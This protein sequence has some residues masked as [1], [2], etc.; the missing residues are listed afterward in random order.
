MPYIL[1]NYVYGQCYLKGFFNA[2]E[3]WR[4]ARDLNGWC[5]SDAV[6]AVTNLEHEGAPKDDYA[7]GYP[8]STHI[9][10]ELVNHATAL[11]KIFASDVPLMIPLRPTDSHKIR[12]TVGDASAEG[13]SIATQYPD[14]TIS[15]RDGLWSEAFAEGGSNLREAQNFGNHLLHEVLAGKHDGCAVWAGTDNAVWLAV[16][17]KGMLSAKHIFYYCTQFLQR[18]MQPKICKQPPVHRISILSQPKTS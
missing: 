10:E 14:M 3:A 13:F 4:G 12:Y 17:N 18:N 8:I 11:L 5:I 6:T 7:R 2:T 15:F 16:W 9:T 1:L